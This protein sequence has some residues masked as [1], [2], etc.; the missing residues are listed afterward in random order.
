[1]SKRPPG[2][3]E[4]L[5]RKIEQTVAGSWPTVV[6]PALAEEVKKGGSKPSDLLPFP[7]ELIQQHLADRRASGASE[8][9]I[10]QEV[11]YLVDFFK[12]VAKRTRG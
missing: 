1:M 8:E 6:E 3:P 10:E 2:V 5:E 11:S 9:E 4:S 12:Q 7:S